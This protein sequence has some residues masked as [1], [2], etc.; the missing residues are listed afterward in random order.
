[1]E[2]IVVDIVKGTNKVLTVYDIYDSSVIES[3]DKKYDNKKNKKAFEKL[4]ILNKPEENY[5]FFIKLVRDLISSQDLYDGNTE[6]S[7]E[8]L[9]QN[10]WVGSTDA[11]DEDHKKKLFNIPSKDKGLESGMSNNAIDPHE[12]IYMARLNVFKF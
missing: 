3:I 8:Y 9:T 7:V 5:G 2:N 6:I 12:Q 1:M 11:Y 4:K 10:G